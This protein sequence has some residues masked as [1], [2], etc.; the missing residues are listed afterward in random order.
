[1]HAIETLYQQARYYFRVGIR[2][3]LLV[4]FFQSS[5]LQQMIQNIP[6]SSFPLT[7]RD[8]IVVAN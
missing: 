7:L 8:G 1:M 4:P 5:S 6:L 3:G 2:L